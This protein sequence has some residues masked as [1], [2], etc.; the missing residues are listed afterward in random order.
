[1][2]IFDAFIFSQAYSSYAIVQS[3]TTIP[4]QSSIYKF[5]WVHCHSVEVAFS[6]CLLPT[7]FGFHAQ[8]LGPVGKS[9][10]NFYFWDHAPFSRCVARVC[11]SSH[12]VSLNSWSS[13]VLHDALAFEWFYTLKCGDLCT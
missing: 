7:T 5:T 11:S 4:K 12:D 6:F 8:R 3:E 9:L 10:I 1:M 13:A 2:T